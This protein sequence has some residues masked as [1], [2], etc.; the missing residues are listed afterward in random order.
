MIDV[1][2]GLLPISFYQE[3]YSRGK[4]VRIL[5]FFLLLGLLCTIG[6]EVTVRAFWKYRYHIPFRDPGRILY[7]YYPEL[8]Y[9][10]LKN[11]TNEDNFYDILLLGGSVLNRKY[12]HV[13]QELL[14]QLAYA[15]H[16]N[17]RI[18]NLAESAH[19]SRDSLLKYAALDDARFELVIFYHG[20]NET[21]ANNA[22]PNIFLNDYSHYSW[23]ETVNAL[24]RYHG[25][26]TF[27][28][29]Y[30]IQ[31]LSGRVR[32]VLKPDQYVP[33]RLPRSDWIRYGHILSSTAA[34]E[35]NLRSI[36]DIAMRRG[37]QVL[38]MTFATYVPKDYL[39]ETFE[40]KRLDYTLHLTPIEIW[41]Q[42][43]NVLSAVAAHNEVVRNLVT[44][45]EG[46]IFVDQAKLM[47]GSGRYFNDPCHFTSRGSYKFVENLVKVLL[48][49]HL[50]LGEIRSEDNLW[51]IAE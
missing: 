11:P 8:R 30:T 31:Y 33:T 20:I 12:G 7:A 4:R 34:F 15:G 17:V 28:L 29:P 26:S 42:R 51:I 24:A 22:P 45:Y 40:E 35:E 2:G 49:K 10:D 47:E 19:T 9:V 13:E 32:Q 41:G 6:A 27:A 38:L 43:D 50:N 21:R 3:I 18:F 44:R 16:H 14:E 37:E 1:G 5:L 25:T 36:L 46:T 39:R 48:P 23:Y